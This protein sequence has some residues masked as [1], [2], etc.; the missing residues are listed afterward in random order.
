MQN[1]NG[2]SVEFA[3]ELIKWW[4]DNGRPMQLLPEI[5]GV[6][7]DFRRLK[8]FVEARGGFEKV[9]R[10]NLWEDIANDLRYFTPLDNALFRQTV[11]ESLRNHYIQYLHPFLTGVIPPNSTDSKSDS[12]SNASSANSNQSSSPSSKPKPKNRIRCPNCPAI[13]SYPEMAT[14]IRCPKCTTIIPIPGANPTNSNANSGQKVTIRCE[15]PTCRAMLSYP[16]GAAMIKCPKCQ[17][18]MNVQQSNPEK[19]ENSSTAANSTTQSTN[20]VPI[21]TEP[22]DD[23]SGASKRSLQSSDEKSTTNSSEPA[24]KKPRI[25]TE[26]LW[27]QVTSRSFA[28]GHYDAACAAE[29]ERRLAEMQA[30]NRRRGTMSRMGG[31]AA[32]NTFSRKPEEPDLLA[33]LN[34]DFGYATGDEYNLVTYKEMADIFEAR[35]SNTC[36]TPYEKEREYWRIVENADEWVHVQYGSDLD[37]GKHGSGFPLNVDSKEKEHARRAKFWLA[38]RRRKRKGAV[39]EYMMHSGWNT[40]NLAEATFLHHLDESVAGV[41]RPMIY[42]GMMFSSF[43]WH[44][45]DNYLYSINYLHTGKPK[46]WY[47]VPSYGADALERTFRKLLPHLFEETPNLLHLLVTQLSPR[48]L[49]EHGVPVYTALQKQGQFVITCPRAYHAGFNL[50]FN[51]AESVNF[52]LEDWLPMCRQAVQDYRFQRSAVV[53]Y[54][55]F[56]LKAAENPDNLPCAEIIHAE[57]VHVIAQEQRNLRKVLAAGITQFVDLPETECR[58][59]EFC[60]YDCYLSGVVCPGHKVLIACADHIDDVC[61]CDRA[62]KRLLVRVPLTRLKATLD[63]LEKYIAEQ[64]AAMEIDEPKSLPAPPESIPVS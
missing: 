9:E 48:I 3:R 51:V 18:I 5:Q 62:Q 20:S 40:N 47:G 37:V 46:R 8:M 39:S 63:K 34:R 57:L 64:R 25:D 22:D 4:S 27:K 56:T 17:K 2:P 30:D 35:W 44:V 15:T 43:C 38:A 28:K 36:K 49:K 60:G 61:P 33:K 52:A 10:E 58:S 23:K 41:T 42:V 7:V 45:E 14:R 26:P 6:V 13:L 21:K 19:V 55:E 59:C 54:E 50:G 53:P 11:C 16:Q 32:R 24:Q 1:R 29:D 31:M 12:K